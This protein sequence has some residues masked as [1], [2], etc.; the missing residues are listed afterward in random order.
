MEL[1]RQKIIDWTK[2]HPKTATGIV[3][4]VTIPLIV[5]LFATGTG[6]TTP[7]TSPIPT[8]T[9]YPRQTGSPQQDI[10]QI[11]PLKKTVI[12]QTLT[13]AQARSLA[14]YRGKKEIDKTKTIFSLK[15][16]YLSRT[17]EI[18]T[19]NNV[20]VFE[21]E[22]TPASTT[23]PYAKISDYKKKYGEPEK[24]MKGS[25]FYGELM[26][27]YIYANLGFAFIGNSYTDEI[28]EFHF[29]TPTTLYD[30]ITNFGEDIDS[31]TNGEQ[32]GE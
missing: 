15:S 9:P 30:Y 5:L 22:L 31:T 20:V 28:F 25:K 27:T 4:A 1:Q 2:T 17:N 24:I 10:K 32:F 18:R 14:G 16:Q 6:P 12:G 29:F 26:S 3:A 23:T 7:G 19:G 8:I 21:R 11:T 13:E